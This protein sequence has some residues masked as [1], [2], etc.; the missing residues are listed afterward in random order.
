MIK[1]DFIKPGEAKNLFLK[2]RNY[3]NGLRKPSFNCFQI[4]GN[5]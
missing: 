4:Y 3:C 2:Q 5:S 1:L